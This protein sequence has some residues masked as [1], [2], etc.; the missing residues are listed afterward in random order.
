MPHPHIYMVSGKIV[1]VSILGLLLTTPIFV[2][3]TEFQQLANI[4]DNC[5]ASQELSFICGAQRPED[6]AQIPGTRWLIASGFT[7]GAGLK[8]V[9]VKSKTIRLWYDADPPQIRPDKAMYPACPGAP[10]PKIF[11]AHGISLRRNSDGRYTLYVVNHGGRQSIDVFGVDANQ[12]EPAL[13][14]KGCV[15]MPDMT[16]ANGVA[17]FDDGTILVTVQLLNGRTLADSV[18]GIPT[19]GVFEWK[20]G[21]SAFRLLPG[22]AVPGNNGIETS[23]DGREFY[24]I[25]FGIHT[26]FV[27][28]RGD[29]AKPIRQ[30]VAPGFMPDN[31]HWDNGRLVLAG[32]V[33][34]EPACGGVRKVINGQADPMRCPRGYV[35]AALDPV[36][37]HFSTIAYGTPNPVYNGVASAVVMDGNVWLGSYQSDKIAYRPL[38]GTPPRPNFQEHQR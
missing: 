19:G 27:F 24:V 31:L 38:P 10:D 5:A 3:A 18:N 8:L 29:T 7:N 30:A 17:A 6:L 12:D 13:I 9:D 32:M 4:P 14:W 25:G 11:N 1:A 35:V 33:D 15:M 28:S 23:P 20:P 16:S 37:M 36:T 26:I 2:S 34:D 21:G 22:T